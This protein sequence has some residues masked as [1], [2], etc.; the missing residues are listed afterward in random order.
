MNTKKVYFKSKIMFFKRWQNKSYSVFNTIGKIIIILMLPLIYLTVF[1]NYSFAQDTMNLQKLIVQSNKKPIL[2]N[3]TF[4]LVKIITKSELNSTTADNLADILKSSLGVDVR[5]RGA[6]EVQADVSIN[7]GTFDQVLILLNGIPMSDAQTGHNSL[8]LPVDL[9]NIESIEILQGPGTRLYG[10]NA[11][12][13]AMNI[14]TKPSSKK[15]LSINLSAGQFDY[16]KATVNMNFKTGELQNLLAFSSSNSSGYSENTDFSINKL[17]YNSFLKLSKAKISFQTGLTTKNYGAYS[18]YTPTFPY[19]YEAINNE[20]ASIKIGFGTK[21]K[22]N[23]NL[24][25]H[26]N[27]DKF[28]LFREDKNWYQHSGDFW[29]R[30]TNDTAKFVQNLYIP[31]VYYQGH[32]YHV[33]NVLGANYNL[34]FSSKIGETVLGIDIRRTSILSNVLG[35]NSDSIPVLFE[36]NAFYTKSASH[37]NLTFYAD[38]SFSINKFRFSAGASLNFNSMFGFYTAFGTELAFKFSDKYSSFVSIN[39]GV[40]MPTFTDLYYKGPSNIGN[41]NL[42]PEKSTSF[43]FGQRFINQFAVF[44]ASVFYRLGKNT[45]DWV[46]ISNDY[47]WQPLNYTQ[48]NTYGINI[49]AKIYLDRIL[50]NRIIKMIYLNYSY[51]YQQKPEQVYISKYVLDYPENSLNLKIVQKPIKNLTL[52]WNANYLQRK[53]TYTFAD[54]NGVL[55]EQNYSPFWLVDFAAAYKIKFATVYVKCSNLLNTQYYDI[56][57]V[58]LPGMWFKVGIKFVF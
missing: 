57:N 50:N 2:F 14:I 28:E 48:I 17:F 44:Q 11:Y 20:M 10:L 49:S 30:N 39:Q 42:V 47:L 19:Q 32:N 1:D 33:T 21:F 18:F 41:E 7:G 24:W 12:S 13:G 54:R 16:K 55:Q 34:I 38:Q 58:K 29:I 26:R 36:K 31:S 6:D 56:N 52:S 8:T 9:D 4:R 23:I 3:E 22:S 51:L 15:S 46:K 25:Y 35:Q 5:Q 45:I 43:E 40:R 53:G 37:D 27:Q